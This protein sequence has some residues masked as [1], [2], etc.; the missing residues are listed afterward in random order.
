MFSIQ[1]PIP[2]E[3]Y[4]ENGT[5]NYTRDEVLSYSRDAFDNLNNTVGVNERD[6]EFDEYIK[7]YIN[8]KEL[9]SEYGLFE[10]W[11]PIIY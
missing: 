10:K 7:S 9:R 2:M 3:V 11:P 1:K 8:R 5:I 6:T 4:H